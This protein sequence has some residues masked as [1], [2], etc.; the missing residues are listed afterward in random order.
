MDREDI[1]VTEADR[2]TKFDKNYS[3]SVRECLAMG[4]H[5]IKNVPANGTF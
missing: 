4:A 1:L 5:N 2:S 3:T